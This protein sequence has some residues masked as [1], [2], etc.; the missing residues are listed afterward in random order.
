[1][2]VG[3]SLNNHELLQ[4]VWERLC[5]NFEPPSIVLLCHV[6][7]SLIIWKRSTT[8]TNVSEVEDNNTMRRA[9]QFKEGVTNLYLFYTLLYGFIYQWTHGFAISF[10][11]NFISQQK[12]QCELPWEIDVKIICNDSLLLYDK[13]LNFSFLSISR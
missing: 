13:N 9:L 7:N 8:N 5:K 3:T 11:H 10:E 6:N 4:S 1:M 2:R 12:F